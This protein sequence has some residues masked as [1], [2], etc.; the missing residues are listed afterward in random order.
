MEGFDVERLQEA[1]KKAGIAVSVDGEF[2][3]GTDTAV[4][5]FQQKKTL[6]AD[7][8]VGQKTRELMA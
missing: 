7:G 5:E 8:I 4:K 1:L 2:G 6:T 3:P